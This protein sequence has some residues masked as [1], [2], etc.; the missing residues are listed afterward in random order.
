MTGPAVNAFIESHTIVENR[1]ESRK[2]DYHYILRSKEGNNVTFSLYDNT[3]EA[4]FTLGI[5]PIRQSYCL[6]EG[7]PGTQGTSGGNGGKAGLGG[8]GGYPGNVETKSLSGKDNLQGKDDISIENSRGADGL[9]GLPGDGG[10][11]G[12]DGRRGLDNGRNEPGKRRCFYVQGRLHIVECKEN[13]EDRVWCWTRK[14]YVRIEH[15]EIEPRTKQQNGLMGDNEDTERR[16]VNRHATKKNAIMT[17]RLRQEYAQFM[18]PKE[19]FLSIEEL[20]LRYSPKVSENVNRNVKGIIESRGSFV[21]TGSHSTPSI[22]PQAPESSPPRQ[23]LAIF[24]VI[25]LTAVFGSFWVIVWIL[26]LM[27]VILTLGIY[28][29]NTSKDTNYLTFLTCL[30]KKKALAVTTVTPAD[31]IER[32]ESKLKRNASNTGMK[33][34]LEKLKKDDNQVDNLRKM[35]LGPQTYV[36]FQTVDLLE[37]DESKSELLGKSLDRISQLELILILSME[38][39][40]YATPYGS[41]FD[42]SAD[43]A[44]DKEE[45]D[46]DDD[47]DDDEKRENKIFPVTEKDMIDILDLMEDLHLEEEHL[48][49]LRQMDIS[50]WKEHLSWL[51]AVVSLRRLPVTWEEDERLIEAVLYL[52]ELERSRMKSFLEFCEKQPGIVSPQLVLQSLRT[53]YAKGWDVKEAFFWKGHDDKKERTLNKILHIMKNDYLNSQTVKDGLSR[54]LH[55]RSERYQENG[56]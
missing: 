6:H 24:L 25:L 2:G 19:T 3:L 49:K 22:P 7:G 17:D 1:N 13:V 30:S 27:M 18:F 47:D 4:V 29:R 53:M 31:I 9:D 44:K 41:S 51:S 10:V 14:K 34:L 23:E 55:L 40:K 36:L 11:G 56:S 37:L 33:W 16:Q 20:L 32:I 5:A 28:N 38:L 46:D 8:E 12:L 26:M 39:D 15:K 54:V 52:K 42:N 50:Q 48:N 21:S 43:A 35:F 45:K